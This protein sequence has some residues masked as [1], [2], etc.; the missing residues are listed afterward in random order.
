MTAVLLS[1][2]NTNYLLS[3]PG[4]W[5]RLRKHVVE[6]ALLVPGIGSSAMIPVSNPLMEWALTGPKLT[7]EPKGILLCKVGAI[8]FKE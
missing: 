4:G 7:S 2:F 6:R 1:A 8:K 5:S 3:F